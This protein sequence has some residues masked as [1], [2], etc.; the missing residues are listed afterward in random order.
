MAYELIQEN[1]SRNDA[2]KGIV[3]NGWTI[4]SKK[5]SICNSTEMNN[6]Q[7]AFGIPPPEMVFGDNHVTLKKGDMKLTFNAKDAL[8]LVDASSNS[9]EHIKVAYAEEWT[10][11]S[12]ANHTDVKDVI[13]PY[14]WTYSTVYNGTLVS[15]PQ[16]EEAET[17]IID[18]QQLKKPE[19][20]LF[21]D[22]IVLYE[23]ELADNGTAILSI[24]LR[25]MPSCFLI[26][27][28][29]FLR[30]DD[31]LFRINDTRLYHEF[32]SQFLIREYTSKEEHYQNIR[33][34]LPPG[35]ADISILND[36]NWVATA[37]P[38]TPQVFKRERLDVS[39]S[40]V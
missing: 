15:G 2:T 20:I 28:R 23:D 3:I 6:L 24:R 32:G 21:Y 31:V 36:A 8:A 33:K 1:K 26:L 4:T 40:A 19:P 14:D 29:F 27:Q 35:K 34:K 12:T 11:K 22:E 38:E 10:R 18:I 16:F 39:A 25:V 5:A 13:K 37:L 7:Q 17:P 9:S 30:V